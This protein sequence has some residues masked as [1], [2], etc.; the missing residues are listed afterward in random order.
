M[1]DPHDISSPIRM[2]GAATI[3]VTAAAA[4]VAGGCGSRTEHAQLVSEKKYLATENR[5]V[6]DALEAK[7]VQTREL[8]VALLEV[9][10]GLAE[11]RGQELAA[12]RTSIRVAKEGGASAT[13]REELRTEVR[14]IRDAVHENLAKLARLEAQSAASGL[15]TATLERQTGELRRSLEE[16]DALV[17]ELDARVRDLSLAVKTQAASL[18]EKDAALREGE[19]RLARKTKEANTAWVAVA[20]KRTLAQKGVVAR[21]GL[22]GAW[23]QTGRFDP[24]VFREVDVTRDLFVEIPAPAKSI[25]IVTAQPKESYR[26]VDADAKTSKLEVADAEA[27]WRGERYLVVMLPD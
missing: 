12:V 19:A 3:A 9:Q 7:N 27:F 13:L 11:I 26:I 22:G 2:L 5:R 18:K 23:T 14:T 6:S 17:K 20:S 25:R 24:D 15:K 21:A 16:K 10:N 8:E 4:L 1:R